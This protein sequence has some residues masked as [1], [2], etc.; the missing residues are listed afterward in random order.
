MSENL[1][2]NVL[3]SENAA[4]FYAQKLGLAP[5]ESASEAEVDRKS[6]V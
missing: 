5:A 6:V 2:S 3:T 1:A 4:E